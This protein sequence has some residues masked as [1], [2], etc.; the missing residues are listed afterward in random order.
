[1][2]VSSNFRVD[3]ISYA[4]IQKVGYQLVFLIALAPES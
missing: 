4:D 1:M 3:S 2:Y